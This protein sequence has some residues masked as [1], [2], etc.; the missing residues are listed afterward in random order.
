MGLDQDE[1]TD[2]E[3]EGKRDRERDRKTEI[4]KNETAEPITQLQDETIQLHQR[5]KDCQRETEIYKND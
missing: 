2:R 3:R 5:Q 4:D 1:R